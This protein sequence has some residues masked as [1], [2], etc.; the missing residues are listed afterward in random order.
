MTALRQRISLALRMA[1]T[2]RTETHPEKPDAEAGLRP[3]LETVG[4]EMPRA[5]QIGSKLSAFALLAQNRGNHSRPSDVDRAILELVR[6]LKSL[7]A[8]I[9]ERLKAFA[10]PFPH[11]RGQMSVA[12]YARSEQPAEN[13]WQR[14]YQDCQSHVERLFALNYQLIGRVL[15]QTD[16]SEKSFG[17]MPVKASTEPRNS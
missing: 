8:G 16:A 7:V 10:Y 2:H 12:D 15:A 5:H 3:L 9:Q 6:E 14:V 17:D 13:D 1:E 4:A 11:A